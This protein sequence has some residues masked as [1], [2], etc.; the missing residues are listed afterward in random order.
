MYEKIGVAVLVILMVAILAFSIPEF[1]KYCKESKKK[2][3]EEK[4]IRK[5]TLVKL[6]KEEEE[7][8]DKER[9]EAERH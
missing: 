4:E 7:G 9:D 3:E 5:R 8:K 1:I 6:K 2:E